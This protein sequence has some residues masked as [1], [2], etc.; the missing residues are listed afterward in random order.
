MN[1]IPKPI[2]F[3]CQFDAAACIPHDP[4]ALAEADRRWPNAVILPPKAHGS[5]GHWAVV[6]TCWRTGGIV[7]LHKSRALAL[8]VKR[9]LDRRGCCKMDA[10]RCRY[11]DW[12]RDFHAIVDLR[13]ALI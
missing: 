2:D 12:R 5:S 11:E 6:T 13:A 9:D 4:Q 1:Y 3:S 7:S 8:E 10:W